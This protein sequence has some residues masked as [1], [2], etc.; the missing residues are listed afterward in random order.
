MPRHEFLRINEEKY[1]VLGLNFLTRSNFK[2]TRL[3]EL[4]ANKTG[5]NGRPKV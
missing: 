3:V 4:Q 2:Y 1:N 5:D